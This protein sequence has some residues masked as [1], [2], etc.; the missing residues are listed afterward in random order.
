MIALFVM[1]RFSV[2]K[3]KI[4]HDED[5]SDF[6]TYYLTVPII[7]V[8]TIFVTFAGHYGKLITGFVFSITT[9]IA[10]ACYLKIRK[11]TD[12][13]S[14]SKWIHAGLLTWIYLNTLARLMTYHRHFYVVLVVSAVYLLFVVLI[15]MMDHNPKIYQKNPILYFGQWALPVLFMIVCLI[16]PMR[17]GTSINIK[18]YGEQSIYFEVKADGSDNYLKSIKYCWIETV[19]DYASLLGNENSEVYQDGNKQ[20]LINLN[21]TGLLKIIA[22]DKYDI[23]TTCER[24]YYVPEEDIPLPIPSDENTEIGENSES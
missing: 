23:V 16:S 14:R 2:V 12:Q 10:F 8:I 13:D 1:L 4:F 7:S 19:E 18:P 5:V 24:W 22:V 21:K 20:I 9:L 11:I 6:W 3:K 15:L 17:G